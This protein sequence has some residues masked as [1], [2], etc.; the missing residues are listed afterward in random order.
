MTQ[1][2]PEV[3]AQPAR[4]TCPLLTQQPG[5]RTSYQGEEARP[6]GL[7]PRPLSPA[8]TQFQL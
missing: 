6:E 5:T 8:T 1:K 2:K 3:S 4:L 7:N